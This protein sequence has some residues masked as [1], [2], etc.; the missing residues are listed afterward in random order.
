MNI[1][2]LLQ[3]ER[4]DICQSRIQSF[5]HRFDNGHFYLACHAALP[6]ALTPDLLYCLWANF[7]Q[8]IHGKP[9]E[10]PWIAVS[11]LLLSGLCEEVGNELY[12]MDAGIR[13]ELLNQ[14][15]N[16]PSFGSERIRE[17]AEFLL[18]YVEQPFNHSDLD[19]WDFAEA[20]TWVSLA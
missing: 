8:D 2:E 3:K 6:V 10:I 7:Q 14:L 12:E 13:D 1:H 20:Q 19:E 9:L 4:K 18:A 15:K 11:D 16:H 17:V 5:R